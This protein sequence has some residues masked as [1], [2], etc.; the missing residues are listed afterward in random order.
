MTIE[1]RCV[2]EIFAAHIELSLCSVLSTDL[3]QKRAR[4]LGAGLDQ[5]PSCHPI[6]AGIPAVFVDLSRRLTHA[7]LP[8]LGLSANILQQFIEPQYQL[9]DARLP[10]Q[11]D[12]KAKSL[13]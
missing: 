11:C 12:W 4:Q 6:P 1:R 7:R 13:G 10:A 3:R 2:P 5:L 8:P 9:R